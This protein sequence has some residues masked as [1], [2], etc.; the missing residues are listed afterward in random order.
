VATVKK[1]VN[2]FGIA[3]LT[4]AMGAA[5]VPLTES[6]ASALVETT[7]RADGPAKLTESKKAPYKCTAKALGPAIKAV[8][9]GSPYTVDS[10]GCSGNWAFVVFTSGGT[11]QVEV[12]GYLK[13]L[14]TWIADNTT[15]VCAKDKLPSSIKAEAC[16]S[17]L[18][19][20]Q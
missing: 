3:A 20:A 2:G 5:V 6:P 9:Q 1:F 14:T 12:L 7:H 19:Q 10:V 15:T 11:K 18:S 13:S 4:L 17:G 8:A 16:K